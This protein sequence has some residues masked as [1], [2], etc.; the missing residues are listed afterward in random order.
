MPPIVAGAGHRPG[1][2]RGPSP[3]PC[4][5]WC[6][7]SPGK[8]VIDLATCQGPSHAVPACRRAADRRRAGIDGQGVEGLSPR[9]CRPWCRSSP[10]KPGLSRGQGGH[11]PGN[12]PYV[13]PCRRS[14]PAWSIDRARCRGPS[15]RPCRPWCRSSRQAGH[16]PGQR[17]KKQ[18]GPPACRRAADR[19][20]P[21][22]STGQRCRGPS[23]AAVP[24]VV[25]IV[26]GQRRA[27]EG[28][29]GHR[30]ATRPPCPRAADRRRAWSIDRAR[31]RGP[32]PAAVPPVP[33]IVAGLAR[34]RWFP[35]TAQIGRGERQDLLAVKDGL[36]L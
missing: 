6:R 19:R 27:V 2:C 9:P 30:R 31:C 13:P 11:R 3:R 4:R 7:S 36:F 16:R 17:A 29:S 26:A 18:I 35:P 28:Q 23:P 10:G 20:R 14:S 12:G 25:P 34:P 33:P 22:Q 8:L 21:V 1:K 32:F 5:P 24:P 15:P